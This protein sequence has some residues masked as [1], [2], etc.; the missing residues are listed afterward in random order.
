MRNLDCC[1]PRKLYI[2]VALLFKRNSL[3][4]EK[5]AVIIVMGEF[6]AAIECKI[7]TLLFEVKHGLVA[8]SL[9]T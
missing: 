4:L 9:D 5:F 8:C 7:G 6:S 3:E 1:L 2:L